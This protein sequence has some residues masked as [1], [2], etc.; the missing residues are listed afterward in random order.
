MPKI[1][2]RNRSGAA[3]DSPLF[4]PST[5]PRFYPDQP[6]SPEIAAIQE[7]FS[8]KGG[9]VLHRASHDASPA[10]PDCDEPLKFG[11]G[12]IGTQANTPKPITDLRNH[13]RSISANFAQKGLDKEGEA[14]HLHNI[15]L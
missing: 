3:D 5:K 11:R 15:A 1:S 13:S 9:G 4:T 8:R 7:I 6:V 14:F 10:P 12:S 2:P